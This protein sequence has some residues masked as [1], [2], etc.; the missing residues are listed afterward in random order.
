MTHYS[1][2]RVIVQSTV[3]RN[4]TLGFR[5]IFSATFL[6]FL[7]VAIV[8]RMVPLR[9]IMGAAKSEN[10]VAVFAEAKTAAQTYTPYAFMG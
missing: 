4:D 9:W 2:T 10:F 7:L 3:K 6:T 1:P 8:D 5:L